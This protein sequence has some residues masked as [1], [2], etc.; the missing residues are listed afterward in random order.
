MN[1][2]LINKRM[3]NFIALTFIV[4]IIEAMSVLT[5]DAQDLAN[6]VSMDAERILMPLKIDGQLSESVYQTKKIANNFTQLVPTPYATP[7][8]PTEVYFF[9]DDNAIYIGANLYDPEPDKILKEYSIRDNMGNADNFSVFLDPFKSG[10]NGFLFRITA[11]GVQLEG[12]VSDNDV[13]FS[14]NGVWDSR[15]QINADGWSVEFKIPYS[16]LRFP[17]QEVQTWR[18]QFEREIRRFR[19][20]SYWSPLDPTMAG[21]VQ[22]AGEINQIKNIVA[23]IRLSLIPY[24]S[25]YLNQ[26]LS[27]EDLGR[28]STYSGAYAVGADL[29]YG[30]NDAFTLDMT[31]IPDFGQVISDREVLNLSPFE[32]FF[33]ENRQFFIEGTEMFNRG[34]LFYSRRVGGRPIGYF[35]PY[36]QLGVDEIVTENPTTTQ[37]FNASKISGRTSQ[38]L[39]LGLFNAIVGESYA[40]IENIRGDKRSVKTN[41]LT[42]YNAIVVDKNLKNNSFATLINTNVWREGNF[43][44]ANALGGFYNFKTK[45]QKYSIEGNASHT[46][47]KM[48]SGKLN[49]GFQKEIAIGKISGEWTYGLGAGIIT[50]NYNPN[51]L[52]F[53]LAPNNQYLY[54]EGAYNNYTPKANKLLRYNYELLANYS[55]LYAPNRYNDFNITLKSFYLYKSRFAFGLN[56]RIE[57]FETYDFFETRS[58]DFNSFITWSQNYLLGGF[59]SSDYRKPIALDVRSNYR[60]FTKN[61]RKS[62]SFSFGPRFRL[63]DRFSLMLTNSWQGVM[64]EPGN[65]FNYNGDIPGISSLYGHRN[66]LTIENSLSG[67]YIFNALMGINVRVRHYWDRVNYT[68]LGTLRN[69]GYINPLPAIFS[70]RFDNNFNFFTVDMQYNYR[71]AAGSDLSIVWKNRIQ[72]DNVNLNANYFSNF[73]DIF[74]ENQ[75]NNI[76]V[77]LLYFLDYQDIKRKKA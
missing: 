9:Y 41:P 76:S 2:L 6:R 52:G 59:I 15:V 66:R 13:D 17:K 36:G 50:E 18:V 48:S 51:D 44:D 28:S 60:H 19:E 8:F 26:N 56:T 47:R 55:R 5:I 71:F 4:F 65:L 23:P 39:G 29:K 43:R 22:Q 11:S 31:L 62:G 14:W 74:G 24:V 32:V 67:Q 12:I 64:R 42:N 57:P 40:T 33:E 68:E 73:I 35:E 53:L 25:L 45:D 70:D 63:N 54:L 34:N 27:A 75:T 69:D 58:Q 77:R 1:L 7:S 38:N 46:V 20:S 72:Y 10:L 49:S 3:Y 30:I 16:S 61:N 21:W 37:L